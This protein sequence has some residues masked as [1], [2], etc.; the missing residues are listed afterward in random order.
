MAEA[1]KKEVLGGEVEEGREKA[2]AAAAEEVGSDAA[3]VVVGAVETAR[4]IPGAVQMTSQTVFALWA[5]KFL[6]VSSA[7]FYR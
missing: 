1:P 7:F 6:T 5:G 3:E 2:G 4:S